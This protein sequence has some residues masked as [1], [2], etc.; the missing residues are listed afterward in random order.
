MPSSAQ[1]EVSPWDLLHAAVALYATSL[2]DMGSPSSG[3]EG[4]YNMLCAE[5]AR[6]LLILRDAQEIVQ[7]WEN[8]H[9]GTNG[10]RRDSQRRRRSINSH[11]MTSPED[12]LKEINNNPV[13]DTPRFKPWQK[14]LPLPHHDNETNG[15]SDDDSST[16]TLDVTP[17]AQQ[18]ASGHHTPNTATSSSTPVDGEGVTS[19]SDHSVT[20]DPDDVLWVSWA[21]R[22]HRM[23]TKDSVD[24]DGM[25]ERIPEENASGHDAGSICS[26]TSATQNQDNATGADPFSDVFSEDSDPDSESD[27]EEE[28]DAEDMFTKG[29]EGFLRA[30]ASRKRERV[31]AASNWCLASRHAGPEHRLLACATFT[32]NYR[33]PGTKVVYLPVI[34]VRKKFRKH[35]IGKFLLERLKSPLVVGPYDAI[36]VRTPPSSVHFFMKNNWT[37]DIILNSRFRE[38]EEIPNTGI[39]LCYLPPFDG[40]YPPLPG[41]QEWNRPE[42]ISNMEDEIDRWKQKSLEA[43]Q[44]QVTCLTRLQQEV[45]R[46]NALLQKQDQAMQQ[47]KKENN[48]LQSRLSRVEKTSTRALIESLEKEAADFE[49]LCNLKY[50]GLEDR[51]QTPFP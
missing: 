14:I 47:M 4:L 50:S 42:T 44:C 46:L 51:H 21:S 6:T 26:S 31:R 1:N 13:S 29:L 5:G 17:E 36:V 3:P 40:H 34:A 2:P 48:R 11:S 38:L 12:H 35:G 8:K 27:M 9:S 43:Y 25:E 22:R 45:M 39:S 30:V 32:K 16:P 41:T 37:N 19:S 15:R 49:R 24:D 28:E 33:I 20:T 23:H 7:D 18:T 10:H